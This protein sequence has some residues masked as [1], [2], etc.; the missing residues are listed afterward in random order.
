MFN[1]LEEYKT[2]IREAVELGTW[3]LNNR[4]LSPKRQIVI[5]EM[6]LLLLQIL[7]GEQIELT[8]KYKFGVIF[9]DEVSLAIF[10]RLALYVELS[11]L[12]GRIEISIRFEDSSEHQKGKHYL[13]SEHCLTIIEEVNYL[14]FG[15]FD[16]EKWVRL[17]ENLSEYKKTSP[18]LDVIV[19]HLPFDQKWKFN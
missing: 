13:S 16:Y 19:E 4:K 11:R 14:S 17:N 8:N 10:K 18:R 3:I 12:N 9:L 5:K 1:L 2:L 15:S 6:Q 7:N